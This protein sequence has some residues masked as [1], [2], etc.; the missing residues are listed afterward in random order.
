MLSGARR[1][2]MCLALARD[3]LLAI[4]T[5]ACLRFALLG[6][7]LAV[8]AGCDPPNVPKRVEAR[9]DQ[10]RA[11]E[12]VEAA[13]QSGQ[14]AQPAEEDESHLRETAQEYLARRGEA[15]PF[16]SG[17][18]APS[19][20]GPVVSCITCHGPHGEGIPELDT[21][22]IGGLAEWYLARQLKYFH[23]GVRAPTAQ[24][25]RGT[26]MR[27]VLLASR[28]D[29]AG[30]EDLAAY[31][32]TFHP[33]PA[34][35]LESGDVGHGEKLF[36]V[37]VACHGADGQGSAA[38]NTPALVDQNGDYLVRQLDNYRTGVRGSD[39]RDVFG[40]QMRP[41]VMSMLGTHE[42]AADV[43]AYIGTLRAH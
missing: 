42:D 8:T 19:A 29:A 23:Q 36:A 3:L 9:G 4:M 32:S 20:V 18:I 14:A 12:P 17:E 35:A 5:P 38:L 7:A 15:K 6:A 30:L 39:S 24:D 28:T 34:P 25:V 13:A 27:A 11:T 2:R 40:Q 26:Q 16:Q 41:I 10:A 43:V 22:R 37:C 31:F 33:Q 21:P 1:R